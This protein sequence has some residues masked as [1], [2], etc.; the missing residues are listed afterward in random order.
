[1]TTIFVELTYVFQVDASGRRWTQVN[2]RRCRGRD[3]V[4]RR[5]LM[6]ECG[7]NWTQLDASRCKWNWMK[8]SAV[9]QASLMPFFSSKRKELLTHYW[10]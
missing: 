4:G 2:V 6:V 9:L 5:W 3:A 10:S 1:M 7:C 8:I